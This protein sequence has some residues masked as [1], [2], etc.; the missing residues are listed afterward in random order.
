MGKGTQNY[1]TYLTHYVI[2]CHTFTIIQYII[3]YY[4]SSVGYDRFFQFDGQNFYI[5]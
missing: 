3:T 2:N 5:K 1:P 4:I